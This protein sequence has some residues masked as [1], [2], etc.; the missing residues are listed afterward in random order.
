MPANEESLYNE[1]LRKIAK[2]AGIGFIGTAIGMMFGFFTRMII[3][4][5]LGPGDYGLISLGVAGLSITATIG[6]LGLP[7]GITRHVSFYKGKG[8]K[9]R[10]KGTIISA[11]K[12]SFP[13]SIILA[14]LLFFGAN[15]ISA[16]LFHDESLTQILQIFAIAVPF[17]CLAQIFLRA[18]IGFQDMRYKA[19]V[20][21]IF[22]NVFKIAVIIL[23]LYLGFEVSG[24]AWGWA[25][26][27]VVMSFLAFYFLEKKVFSVFDTEV[28]AI[29]IRK[30]L[31]SF[32]WP[33]TL[34][35]ASRLIFGWMGTLML[36]YF[37][38]SYDV[39]IYNAALPVA[40]LMQIAL[41]SSAAIFMPVISELYSLR[42]YED[43]RRT[44][45][46]VTKWIFSI[47]FPGFLLIILFAKP[48]MWILFGSEYVSGAMA[49]CILAFGYLIASAVGPTSSIL[50]A[51]GKTK[52]IM[53]C[54]FV[55]AGINLFLNIY[56]IPI[57]G[58]N[59]AAIATASSFAFMNIFTF[60]FVYKI[61]RMQPFRMSFLK[62]IFASALACLLVYGIT[63]YLIGASLFVLIV[64]LF[65]FLAL[66][67]FLLLLFKGF[68]EEDLMI[69]KAIEERTGMRWELVRKIIG[70]FL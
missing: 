20:E 43:I 18:T 29:S 28:K 63:E 67:F 40:G 59:G 62:P 9:G 52:V 51:F 3:A 61:G 44:Y 69:M 41:A 33:I 53:R 58:V 22:Q 10:I 37:I 65:V 34:V 50:A 45:S 35:D 32:S 19:Y 26:A 60:L 21:D 47:V 64:M 16:N 68:E 46:M 57:Y 31:F 70:R 36:G 39:G 27:I 42:N 48:I 17:W 24:A 55:G 23:L 2:G 49:L 66:Y 25:I 38:T 13:I 1:S 54:Y 7:A 11:L 5:F 30:E 15:W 14:C 12:I 56:L 8:D 6:L 4:R